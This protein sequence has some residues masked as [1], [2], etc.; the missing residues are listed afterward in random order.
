LGVE[1]ILVSRPVRDVVKQFAV[2]YSE[3]RPEKEDREAVYILTA[4]REQA[5]A[6]EIIGKRLVYYGTKRKNGETN[7]GVGRFFSVK[8]SYQSQAFV[9]QP[10]PQSG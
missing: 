8:T 6:R 9:L 10:P 5:E 4:T 3:S 1:E 7:T 2:S